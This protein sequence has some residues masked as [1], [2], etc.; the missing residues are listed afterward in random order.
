MKDFILQE[1]TRNASFFLT[2]G[3]G[4]V[5]ENMHGRKGTSVVVIHLEDGDDFPILFIYMYPELQR[6]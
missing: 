6:Y 2:I 1:I 5:M 3:L 4:K